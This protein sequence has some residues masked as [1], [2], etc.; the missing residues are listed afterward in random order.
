MIREHFLRGVKRDDTPCPQDGKTRAGLESSIGT[1]KSGRRINLRQLVETDL[2]IYRGTM[3]SRTHPP[4]NLAIFSRE[5]VLWNRAAL[6]S[7]SFG[8]RPF[9]SPP[10]NRN[11]EA[12]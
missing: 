2:R 6:R 12:R 10:F 11:F 8:P 9:L 3:T 7:S 4:R 1:E 5:P